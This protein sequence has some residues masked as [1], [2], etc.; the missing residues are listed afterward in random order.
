MDNDFNLFDF[1]KAVKKRYKFIILFILVMTVG[2]IVYSLNLPLIYL[3][4]AVILV[5]GGEQG[6]VLSLA[7]QSAGINTGGGTGRTSSSKLMA[8]LDS[9]TFMET[10]INRFH[11]LPILVG[12]EGHNSKFDMEL[13]VEGYKEV[14]K[15]SE[16]KKRSTLTIS[17]ELPDPQLSAALAN[18]ILEELQK[19]ISRSELTVSKRQRIFI[20]GRVAAIRQEL[21]KAGKTL[22]KYYD[23]DRVSATSA[24]AKDLPGDLS[25]ESPPA[26]GVSIPLAEAE[27]KLQALD[28]K[29][30]ASHDIPQRVYLEYLG[31]KREMLKLVNGFLSQQYEMARIEEARD[32]ISF[33]VLD[34]A[35]VPQRRIR[36]HRSRI[37]MTAFA[38]SFFTAL[39]LA[40]I[41]DNMEKKGMWPLKKLKQKLEA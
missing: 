35:E 17:V 18:G 30:D 20:E 13:A 15:A 37:V 6:G 5:S 7:L 3:S 40:F 22:L 14:V 23:Q 4:R 29:M 34:S 10:I 1:Y 39:F 11:L 41:L 33:Q 25:E 12:G 8:L 26:D 2:T 16:D 32:S 36:P 31:Q 9:R 21:L 19:S 24:L 38:T 28:K 27:D